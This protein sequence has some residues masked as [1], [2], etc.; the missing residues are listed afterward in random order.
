MSISIFKQ[1]FVNKLD[2]K[3]GCLSWL[4]LCVNHFLCYYCSDLSR[5]DPVSSGLKFLIGKNEFL[6]TS[7]SRCRHGD[8]H[9]MYILRGFVKP[10]F[11][12]YLGRG[13]IST[14]TSLPSVVSDPI[15]LGTR[16]VKIFASETYFRQGLFLGG[17]VSTFRAVR[18]LLRNRGIDESVC[19]GIAGM[20]AGTWITI[21]RNTSL[22]LYLFWKAAEV[23]Y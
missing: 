6:A 23:G 2:L 8:S 16:L 19:R 4:F 3:T 21:S 15:T 22:T 20:L 14:A 5:K 7:P 13:L 11:I 10:F 1:C 12:G 18:C 9:I 17:A